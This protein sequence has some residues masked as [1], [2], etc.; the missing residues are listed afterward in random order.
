MLLFMDGNV[1]DCVTRFFRERGHDVR[2]VR[3]ELPI[4]T[5]DQIIAT[6]VD[7]LE[8]IILTWNHKDFK[9]RA[10]WH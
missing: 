6:V 9:S 2:L 8:G 7:E 4:G 5:P 1:P 3:E 10:P